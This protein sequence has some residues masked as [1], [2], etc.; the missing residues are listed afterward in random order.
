MQ[1]LLSSSGPPIPMK[2]IKTQP[3]LKEAV[4]HRLKESII[5]GDIPPGSKLV[6]TQI[7][8]E[9]GV[10]RTPLREAVNRL[11]QEGLLQII[12]RRGTF[13]RRHS[14]LEILES[15]EIRE[16]LEGLAAR[17]AARQ[18]TPDIVLKM[19]DCFSGFSQKNVE[20]SIQDYARQNV[21]FHHLIIQASGNRRLIEIIRN[22]YDQMDLVRLHT[23]VLPGRARKSLS[24]HREIIRLIE[25]K[26]GDLAEKRLREHI[27]DL[28]RAVKNYPHARTPPFFSARNPNPAAFDE[29]GFFFS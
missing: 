13:V 10:S 25:Q 26:K 8:R 4:Y 1:K 24:E 21:R 12:P 23:I 16:A 19:K 15:L 29:T 6:E 20:Q 9:L 18:A 22:L 27:R 3:N 7:S 11:S 2:A 17:L 5:G 14:L 28:R